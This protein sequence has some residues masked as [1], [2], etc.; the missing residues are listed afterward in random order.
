MAFFRAP[1]DSPLLLQHNPNKTRIQES[2]MSILDRIIED[3]RVAVEP[4]RER[5]A[6][7]RE[8]AE[9]ASPAR[10]FARALR[11]SDVAVIAEFKRRS[12]SAG[13]IRRE[14]DV[15]EVVSGYHAAG[16]AA[17]SVLTD[18][19]YF[20]GALSD[21]EAAR[22]AVPLPVIRKDFVIDEVQ[23]FEARAV[24]ADAAL[25]IVRVLEQER[26]RDLI[27][28]A[29]GIGLDTLIEVHAE[30]ELERAL[31]AGARVVGV[32]NRDLATFTT[33]LERSVR[34][35]P[36][37]PAEIVLVAESGIRTGADVARMGEAGIDAVLVGESVM[38]AAGGED[39]GVAALVGKPKRAR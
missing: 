30:G 8:R 33:D 15:A 19:S 14:A 36:G 34:L 9:A 32:N 3:K 11:R 10:G 13:W 18:E 22:A 7:L 27:A 5:R 24:G 17:L 35:A 39:T 6:A 37:V 1:A 25:L 29:D 2:W 31:A 12:P 20:G 26:L 38:S 21:L 28:A 16:A 4:L 23:L